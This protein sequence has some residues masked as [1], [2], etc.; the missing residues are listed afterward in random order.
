MELE[1]FLAAVRD[2]ASPC[3][4]AAVVL[5]PD[6]SWRDEAESWIG[7]GVNRVVTL[8]EPGVKLHDV[9]AELLEVAPRL[10]RRLF[11]RVQV[12][13]LTGT[14]RI[15]CQSINVSRT[16]MLLET[17]RRYSPATRVQIAFQLPDE[18]EPCTGAAEVVR[19]TTGGRERGRGIAVRFDRFDAGAGE[20]L[21]RYLS[22][23]APG[24]AEPS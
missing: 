10:H 2:P 6:R 19:H 3:R 23:V 8:D 12:Q 11:V 14:E 22:R 4:R 21:E 24:E 16:G 13:T 7:R 15:V 17:D 18:S 9:V 1:P 5:L 20:R